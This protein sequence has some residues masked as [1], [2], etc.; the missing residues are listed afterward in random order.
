MT[1]SV[2]LGKMR[3]RRWEEGS[4]LTI[5]IPNS[6]H[7]S[8]LSHSFLHFLYCCSQPRTH[9]LSTLPCNATRRQSPLQ[10]WHPKEEGLIFRMSI[11]AGLPETIWFLPVVLAYLLIVLPFS[12]KGSLLGKQMYGHPADFSLYHHFSLLSML[13]PQKSDIKIFQILLN[14]WRNLKRA[15]NKLKNFEGNTIPMI[16]FIVQGKKTE[17]IFLFRGS[18]HRCITVSNVSPILKTMLSCTQR[19]CVCVWTHASRSGVDLHVLL[20]LSYSNYTHSLNEISFLIMY[21]TQTQL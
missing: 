19:L 8:L 15:R 7:C 16:F 11:H 21:E 17:Y 9:R 3:E 4:G 1:R 6:C 14:N 12:I 2:Y 20:L 18:I 5:M 10:G 13:P